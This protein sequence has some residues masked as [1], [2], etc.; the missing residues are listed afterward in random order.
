VLLSGFNAKLRG[1]PFDGVFANITMDAAKSHGDFIHEYAFLADEIAS[2]S[3]L[4]QFD[5]VKDVLAREVG[6]DDEQKLS[7]VF[8]IAVWH[9]NDRRSDEELLE[10]FGLTPDDLYPRIDADYGG[11]GWELQRLRGVIAKELGFKAVEMSDEHGTSLY[12]LEDPLERVQ[13]SEPE[14]EMTM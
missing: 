14:S 6:T 9:D 4:D 5:K 10:D 2:S 3:D 12:V 7:A 13:L 1:Y 8:E 11:I